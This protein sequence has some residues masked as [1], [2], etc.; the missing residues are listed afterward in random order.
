MV[1]YL[2]FFIVLFLSLSPRQVCWI[3]QVFTF[4]DGFIFVIVCFPDKCVGS[5][6]SQDGGEGG[7][8]QLPQR[9]GYHRQRRLPQGVAQVRRL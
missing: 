7:S 2:F 5:G 6:W 1:F 9:S 3:G 4:L 8:V